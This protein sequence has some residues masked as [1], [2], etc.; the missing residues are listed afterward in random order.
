M[1]EGRRILPIEI[2]LGAS[3]DQYSMTGLRQSM[4]DLGLRRGFV[5]TTAREG[6]RLSPGVEV[7]PWDHIASGQV[8]LF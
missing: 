7:V 2:R 4:K 8:D 6:R 3:V 5:V 1:V